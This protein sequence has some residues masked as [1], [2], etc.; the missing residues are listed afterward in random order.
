MEEKKQLEIAISPE[1]A[2]GVYSN[3][4]IISHSTSEFVLDFVQ[5]LPGAPK[6][7]VKSRIVLTPE[8]AKR[9]L[10]ALNDNVLKYE[11][12]FGAIKLPQSGGNNFAAP[13]TMFG[14]GQA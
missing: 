14:N 1:V 10:N 6:A 13:I 9:L 4:V 11:R 8:H 3:L 2:G 12:Q 5:N 7:N